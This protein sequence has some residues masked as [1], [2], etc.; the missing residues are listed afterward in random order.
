METAYWSL[1][2]WKVGLELDLRGK[3]PTAVVGLPGGVPEQPGADDAAKKDSTSVRFML[4]PK[5]E[6]FI[7]E[8]SARKVCKTRD[9]QS[10]NYGHMKTHCNSSRLIFSLHTRES[11][12]Q[13]PGKWMC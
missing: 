13:E 6:T 11:C 5:S 1:A 4:W 12:E 10:F 9:I 7:M 3:L 2:S 8:S